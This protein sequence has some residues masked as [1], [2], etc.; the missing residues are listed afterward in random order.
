M[1]YYIGLGEEVVSSR[2]GGSSGVGERV[3]PECAEGG[4]IDVVGLRFVVMDERKPFLQTRDH[5]G[6]WYDRL[7]PDL[8]KAFLD[9]YRKLISNSNTL[10][11]AR[12]LVRYHKDRGKTE[13]QAKIITA[14]GMPAFGLA[15]FKHPITG[16]DYVIHTSVREDGEQVI[17][18]IKRPSKGIV[19][20]LLSLPA[21]LIGGITKGVTQVINELKDLACKAAGSDL[22]A[23]ALTA[24]T[25]PEAA[26]QGQQIIRTVC[27][28]EV[29]YSPYGTTSSS[30]TPILLI[31][32]AALVAYFLL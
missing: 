27:G 9:K 28:Q 13:E 30:L 6:G 20:R 3:P 2:R 18:E 1:S 10:N 22:A 5:R 26:A 16:K 11:M 19:G 32:G 8:K 23:L 7:H 14:A 25:G 4:C 15:K 29:D 12:S 31:G 21:R 17:Y 24:K